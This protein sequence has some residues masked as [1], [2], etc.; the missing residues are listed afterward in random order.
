MMTESKRPRSPWC[1]LL[2]LSNERNGSPMCNQISSDLS[3]LQSAAAQSPG[4]TFSSKSCFNTISAAEWD[5]NQISR[6]AL[7]PRAA[8]LRCEV[9][10]CAGY[11]VIQLLPVWVISFRNRWFWLAEVHLPSGKHGF[12]QGPHPHGWN[13]CP[14]FTVHPPGVSG[15]WAV[16]KHDIIPTAT[17]GRMA[18]VAMVAMVQPLGLCNRWMSP[19]RIIQIFCTV[20]IHSLSFCVH[21]EEE[22]AASS[23]FLRFGSAK[24]TLIQ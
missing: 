8:A 2:G 13:T 22:A 15:H 17:L 4:K 14:Q 3:L 6:P 5:S 23:S 16:M 7:T 20:A 18:M 24:R 21:E 12:L 11:E 10:S 1:A 19:P 9:F